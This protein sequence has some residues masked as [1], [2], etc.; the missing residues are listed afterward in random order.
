MEF[1]SQESEG[2]TK[3]GKPKH[4]AG[5]LIVNGFV[6]SDKGRSQKEKSTPRSSL[7][8]FQ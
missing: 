7:V 5:A 3:T 6:S 4:L 2:K 1:R 8:L